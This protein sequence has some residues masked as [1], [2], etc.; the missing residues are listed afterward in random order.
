M[1][2][3]PAPASSYSEIYQDSDL[4]FAFA[5]YDDKGDLHQAHAFIKCRDFYN[6]ALVSCR[7]GVPC[8]SIYGFQY[9]TEKYPINFDRTQQILKGDNFTLFFKN[10]PILQAYED[11]IGF[12]RTEVELI[13]G[14]N[15]YHL[16]GPSE[17]L[18]STVMISLYTHILR[19][20]YQYDI[21]TDN[22]LTFMEKC[23]DQNGNASTYQRAINK[24]DL[25][26]LIAQA[27]AI[28]PPGCLPEKGMTEIVSVMPIHNNTGIVSWANT[29]LGVGPMGGF[30]QESQEAYKQ[31]ISA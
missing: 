1:A 28:F 23:A 6:E 17:W 30:Y 4:K 26:T 8:P 15:L 19:C 13:E 7:L 12:D 9:P 11:S 31:L 22:F 3:I 27:N 24:I 20:L 16:T 29:I 5:V 25:H 2:F 21:P 14:T 10:L 18:N